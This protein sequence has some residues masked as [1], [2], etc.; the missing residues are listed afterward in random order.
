M[1]KSNQDP[2]IVCA[3]MDIKANAYMAPHFHPT[4]GVALRAFEASIQ[5]GG[6]LLSEYPSDFSL[7]H[8]GYYDDNSGKFLNLDH[9]VRL[10]SAADFVKRQP[11][12]NA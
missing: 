1:Q 10:G 5:K 4:L 8:L 11:Q 6:T 12:A 7:V 3:V 2:L 9:P